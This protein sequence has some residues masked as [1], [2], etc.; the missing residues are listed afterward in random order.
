M[1]IVTFYCQQHWQLLRLSLHSVGFQQNKK[2]VQSFFHVQLAFVYF[3]DMQEAVSR[4]LDNIGRVYARRSEF[5]KAI[6]V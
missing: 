6:E 1:N 4:G 3:S 5:T 2:C